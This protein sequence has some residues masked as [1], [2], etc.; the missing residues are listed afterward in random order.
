L[1]E[2][3]TRRSPNDVTNAV[4]V[5][6]RNGYSRNDAYITVLLLAAQGVCPVSLQDGARQLQLTAPRSI[7]RELEPDVL[8]S[9]RRDTRE[10][11]LDVPV[12]RMCELE[13]DVP[14][15]HISEAE[16]NVPVIRISEAE[17]D[18]PVSR[19]SELDP[20]VPVSDT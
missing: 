4:G 20:D 1:Y 12:S 17:P 7:T 3:I 16:P 11:E 6:V 13:S 10:L 15:S 18:V 14:V 19:I 8:V 2:K 5:S 9:H